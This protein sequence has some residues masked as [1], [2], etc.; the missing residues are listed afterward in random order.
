MTTSRILAALFVASVAAGA[1]SGC[2][3]VDAVTTHEREQVFAT[4]GDAAAAEAELP[5][6]VPD[7]STNIRMRTT[8]SGPDE[9]VRFTTAEPLA[10]PDCEPGTLT[11]PPL[12]DTTW[13]PTTVPDDG[14]V[15]AAWQVF[16]R[17]GAHYAW[18]SA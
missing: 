6:F 4:H 11:D 13:W 3:V 9:L 18:V 17:D 10:S 16:E 14:M 12:L 8:T 1:L 7:D 15:C 5:G 2:A